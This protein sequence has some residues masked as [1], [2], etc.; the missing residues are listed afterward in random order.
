MHVHKIHTCTGHNAALYALAPGTGQRHFLTAGGDGWIV[1]WN[2]DNPENGRVVAQVPAQIFA[3]C[4]LDDGRLVAGNMN[5]GIHWIDLEHP[6]QTRNLQHH[7]K[8][9]FALKQIG[10]FVYSCGGDGFLTRWLAEKALSLESIQ[11]SH[12]SLRCLAYDAT[13]GWLA[14]GGSDYAI[15]VLNERTMALQRV[16]KMAHTSSVFSLAFSPDGRYLWSGGRDAMLRI[17]DIESD[18]APVSAQP[19]HLYTIND[20]AFSPD[21]QW[22]ITAS[23]D[24][25]IKCWDAHS[26]ALLKVIDTLR[27]G[28]HPRSVNRLMWQDGW[29]IS[30]GDDRQAMIWEI[31]R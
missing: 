22:L 14:I 5:G 17:W 8:G 28:S 30:A 19:A 3:L 26:F 6:D 11:L 13:R 20:M 4:K 21:G 23:R 24:R 9:V 2:L 27:N 1:A 10:P 12:Q 7:R 31:N 29:L 15:Y 25:T 16:L 18:F